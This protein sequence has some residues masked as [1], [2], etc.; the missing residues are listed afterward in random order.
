MT[1]HTKGDTIMSGF[2]HVGSNHNDAFYNVDHIIGLE[3][4]NPVR[5]GEHF[6]VMLLLSHGGVTYLSFPTREARTEW[7]QWAKER[8]IH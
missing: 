8:S 4:V 3:T 1:T 2:V 5:E 6:R 7:L